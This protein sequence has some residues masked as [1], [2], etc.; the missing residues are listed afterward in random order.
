MS[1]TKKK[2]A[3]QLGVPGLAV[4]VA[5]LVWQQYKPDEL[6]EG[7]AGSNGRIEAVEIDI[8]ARASGRVSDILVKEGDFIHA[9]DVL[10]NMDVAVLNAQLKEAEAQLQRAQIGIDAAQNQVK[11]RA[12]EIAAAQA[13][14]AQRKVELDAA[15]KQLKRT[16]D[17]AAKG[18]TSQ[19]NLDDD[20]ARF[21]GA[22]AAV[23]AAR[24]QVAAAEAAHSYAESQVVA[25]RSAVAAAKATVQ[26]IDVDIEDSRLK[27][28]R[29]GR[30]QYIV[31]RAGEV[32]SAGSSVL[33]MVDLTDVYMTFFLPT[34]QA[35]RLAIG[36]EARIILDAAPQ[37]II[38]AR[39]SFVADVAQFTPK[40]VE[41][42]VERQKLMFRIKASIE[43]EL[44]RQH[45]SHVK[46]GL[47]GMAYVRLDQQADWP[48]RLQLRLPE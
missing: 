14:V 46:T 21:H 30:V 35:G 38:P 1:P 5:L 42:A 22:K 12:A 34:E 31:A 18:N 45:L 44:L 29:D 43:P 13:V 48:A 7:F 17:L 16:R 26:R 37:Y 9:G 28:P 25:A 8:A 47:P 39:I 4:V 2:L 6:A 19:Q 15:G 20:Q 32:I 11:Q 24:A 33:N 40:T 3:V 10:V 41:T 23:S 36:S 27:S